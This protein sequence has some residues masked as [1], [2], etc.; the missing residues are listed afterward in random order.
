VLG[1]PSLFGFAMY[2]GGP[3]VAWINWIMIGTCAFCTAL[4]LAVSGLFI[5]SQASFLSLVSL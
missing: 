5:D 4:V 2:T 1:L 3:L